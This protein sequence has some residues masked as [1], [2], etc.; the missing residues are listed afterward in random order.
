MGI[1]ISFNMDKNHSAEVLKALE[2][3]K[4]KALQAA[5]AKAAGYAKELCPVD[6]GQLRD[7]IGYTVEEDGVSIG[8]DVGYAAA[9][10]LGTRKRHPRPY[11]A[12]AVESN[13]KEL[14][15]TIEDMLRGE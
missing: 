13:E 5:G 14:I 6:T 8:S 10:E 3:Q 4:E 11:L 1:S 7:S 9:V 2:A 12:P 15:Q